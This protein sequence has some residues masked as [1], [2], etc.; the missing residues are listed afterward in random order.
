MQLS[1]YESLPVL[2]DSIG[3][4][5]FY[6]KVI[7]SIR[8]IQQIKSCIVFSYAPNS[9][10]ISIISDNVIRS[11][12]DNEYCQ[13][14]YLL[15]P[16]YEWIC[17]RQAS[18]F[19]S[20]RDIVRQ[21]FERST[22]YDEFYHKLGWSNETN[23]VIGSINNRIIALSFTTESKNLSHISL[24]LLPFFNSV[25]AAIHTH[26]SINRSFTPLEKVVSNQP[27]TDKIKTILCHFNLTPREQEI[28]QLILEGHSSAIISSLCFVSEGTIKNHRKS[29]YRK[30][31]IKSQ[32]EL[33]KRFI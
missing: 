14:A 25:K 32:G 22:Y 13:S 27:K 3:K 15:D 26:E 18:G 4:L 21:D 12:L 11:D 31:G 5:E 2:I 19:I 8:V 7:D 10:P 1:A 24:E 17:N 6:E 28:T 9:A 20:L 23:F 16:F 30:L 29:I 33:F